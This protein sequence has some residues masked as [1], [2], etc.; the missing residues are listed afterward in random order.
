MERVSHPL[1][2]ERALVVFD[3]E[4]TGTDVNVD[5]IVEIAL[6]RLEP[7]GT[8]AEHRFLINPEVSIPDEARR[9]HGISNEMVAGQP[10]FAELAPRLLELLADADLAGF[11]S[12]RFDVPLLR[13]EFQRARLE[14]NLVGVRMVDTQVIFH[15]KE[16]RDLSAAYRTF[17]GKEHEG[18]HGAL[19]D[20]R[21]T[22]EVL[23]GQLRHYTDLPRDVGGLDALFN[24]PD[25]RFLDPDRRLKWRD[26]QVCLNFGNHKNRPL[27]DLRQEEPA[28]LDWILSKDFNDEVKR[29]VRDALKGTYPEPPAEGE[30]EA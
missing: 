4:T 26:G 21:A 22:L 16:P 11:N 12:T 7:D 15:K 8:E 5:R 27:R 19:A 28:Y 17:C 2:L 10:T 18:A 6:I 13:N 30:S 14:W 9:V 1:Q 24:P 29:I 25:R 23:M 20:T 3:T